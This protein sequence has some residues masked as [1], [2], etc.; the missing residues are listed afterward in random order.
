VTTP[1]EASRTTP[2]QRWILGLTSLASFMISLDSLVVSTAL[3]SLRQDLNATLDSLVWTVNAY[4]LT[5]A[6]LLLTGAALGDKFGRRRMFVAG[7]ALFVIASIACALATDVSFLIGARAVQGV[8][9][10]LVMPLAMA[11]LSAAFPPQQRGKALGT[12]ISITGLATFLGPFVGGLLTEKLSWEWIF[13]LNLPIGLI[14]IALVLM[15]LEE[16]RG[17]A[18]V[19]DL[20]GVILVTLAVFGLVW[21][22]QQGPEAGWGSGEVL[23]SLIGGAIAMAVF[24]VWESRTATPLVP[25]R[26]LKIKAFSSA[27]VASFFLFA[28]IYGMNFMLAQFFQN[29]QGYGPLGAGL[30][31]MPLTVG[32]LVL[33]RYAGSLADKLGERV[34]VVGGLTL[35]AAGTGLAAFIVTADISYAALIVPLTIGS[36]GTVLAIPSTQRAVIGAVK[37]QEIGQASGVVNMLRYFGGVFGIAILST[38]FANAGGSYASRQAFTDGFGPSLGVIAAFAVAGAIVGLALPVRTKVPAPPVPPKPQPATVE[39]ES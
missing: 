29:G 18:G 27:N 15:R 32:V 5:F 38:V 4:N 7:L 12:F 6:A 14:A 33:G 20:G 19:F 23:G 37:L 1:P 9:A 21:G 8:G 25:L 13:W 31:M 28:Q 36:I 30:R 17:P 3:P 10:A 2:Q 24:F 16:S 34:L 11:Q 35:Q 26:F 39:A 22:L